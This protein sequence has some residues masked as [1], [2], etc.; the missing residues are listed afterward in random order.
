M[1]KMKRNN[2]IDRLLA[3]FW[4]AS[5]H[6]FLTCDSMGQDWGM[7]DS[8]YV[9]ACPHL[10]IRSSDLTQ[11]V[12]QLGYGEG[13]PRHRLQTT[14]I[15]GEF[16]G[17]SGEWWALDDSLRAFDGYFW[18][19]PPPRG[20]SC[21]SELLQDYGLREVDGLWMLRFFEIH[22]DFGGPSGET[23]GFEIRVTRGQALNMFRLM[24]RHHFPLQLMDSPGALLQERWMEI[25]RAP[26]TGRD[27]L[28]FSWGGEGGSWTF[29]LRQSDGQ[30]NTFIFEFTGGTC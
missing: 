16:Q 2:R 1:R 9:A 3:W 10:N 27:P 21:A 28:W 18:P 14:G 13:I 12:D 17:L 20:D 15:Q 30:P 4:G 25:M 29:T 26:W 19:I 22:E 6:L 11:V 7:P 5:L 8:L 23:F 24:L